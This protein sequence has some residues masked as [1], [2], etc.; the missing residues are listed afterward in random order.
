MVNAAI[1][2]VE[3]E[4][5]FCVDDMS[6]AKMSTDDWLNRFIDFVIDIIRKRFNGDVLVSSQYSP[7]FLTTLIVIR[8]SIEDGR[9]DEFKNEL[10]KNEFYAST[11]KWI[12]AGKGIKYDTGL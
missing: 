12:E 5:R 3:R 8:F 7:R 2:K 1:K 4:I 11:M 6:T 10:M 9:L